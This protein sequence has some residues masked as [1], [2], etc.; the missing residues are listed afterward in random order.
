M[1]L[2]PN[3]TPLGIAVSCLWSLYVKDGATVRSGPSRTQVTKTPAEACFGRLSA[4]C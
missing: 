2:P 3:V 1:H 4:R